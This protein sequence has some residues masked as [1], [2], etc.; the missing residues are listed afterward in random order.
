C[1]V[2]DIARWVSYCDD[3][4]H[5]STP[6]TFCKICAKERYFDD[7]TMEDYLLH[8]YPLIEEIR[9]NFAMLEGSSVWSYGSV[10]NIYNKAADYL[11]K[12]QVNKEEM[13]PHEF[14]EELKDILYEESLN[15][16]LM[17]AIWESGYDHYEGHL[18]GDEYYFI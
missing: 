13:K 10:K 18:F 4:D 3:G 14:S 15:G 7:C 17:Y 9:D 16:N 11:A 8:I 6:N 1:I 5:V 2:P 12:L